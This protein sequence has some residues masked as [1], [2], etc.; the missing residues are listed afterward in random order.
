MDLL[1]GLEDI[2][3]RVKAFAGM[4]LLRPLME[5]IGSGRVVVLTFVAGGGDNKI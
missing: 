2:N 3:Y 1:T 5:K 4:N